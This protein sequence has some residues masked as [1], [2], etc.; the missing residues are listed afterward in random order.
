MKIEDKTKLLI[1]KLKTNTF[2]Y[3]QRNNI[4]SKIIIE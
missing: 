3:L 1:I 2:L 4:F